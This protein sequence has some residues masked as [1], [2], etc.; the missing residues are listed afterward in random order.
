MGLNIHQKITLGFVLAVFILSMYDAL[1]HLF[2]ATLHILFESA[3]FVLDHLIEG[4]LETGTHE[5]QIIVFYM[6]I[7]MIGGGLYQLY[8]QLP[9]WQHHL[10]Q[11]L[12]RQHA[13]AL[14]QWQALSMPWKIV[15]WSFF[16]TTLNCWL[17][18]T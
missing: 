1:L 11:L 17:F 13:E 3:E 5:T 8:R 7:S 6:L 4:F 10:K 12:Q 9:R 2:L 18:L 15:W 16:I 14:A